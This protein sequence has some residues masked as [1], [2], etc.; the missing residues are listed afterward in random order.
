MPLVLLKT[1]TNW[2]AKLSPLRP[3]QTSVYSGAL[4][5]I[6]GRRV[7]QV[8]MYTNDTGAEYPLGETQVQCRCGCCTCSGRIH[9]DGYIGKKVK[10]RIFKE[11][12]MFLLF[13]LFLFTCSIEI[14]LWPSK[15]RRGWVRLSDWGLSEWTWLNYW[16]NWHQ[17]KKVLDRE[18]ERLNMSRV[19]FVS[20]L[21]SCSFNTNSWTFSTVSK[22]RGK[23]SALAVATAPRG[24]KCW[25]WWG[26]RVARERRIAIATAS[27]LD[28]TGLSK[29][30]RVARGATERRQ[31][32]T[33]E[34]SRRG[35][36][37]TRSACHAKVVS[38]FHSFTL[39]F[40]FSS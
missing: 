37:S 27:R 2:R 13:S 8:N 19:D 26:W 3:W 18:K 1:K 31:N 35:N 12:E 40:S 21:N 28:H 4:T 20:Q 25:R 15:G 10:R 22:S 14:H 6:T 34:T 36:S 11:A 23:C 7:T 17:M 39:F 30:I 32:R 24:D 16:V 5:S 33:E 38:C 29:Y 9:C